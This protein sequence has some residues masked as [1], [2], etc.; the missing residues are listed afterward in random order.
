[1]QHRLGGSGA[2]RVEQ[3]ALVSRP[4]PGPPPGR[5]EQ[6]IDR[7][8]RIADTIG[9]RIRPCAVDQP[10]ITLDTDVYYIAKLPVQMSPWEIGSVFLAAMSIA[11]VATLYPALLAGRL[12]PVEGLRF[13]HG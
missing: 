3:D 1:M 9:N 10:G 2:W 12:R 7:E 8:L 4:G 13:D 6:V 5:L 11:L